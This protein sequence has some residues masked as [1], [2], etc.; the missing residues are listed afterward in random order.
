MIVLSVPLKRV[1]PEIKKDKNINLENFKSNKSKVNS[2]PRW[3][4]L[5]KLL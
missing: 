4:E 3:N 1:N 5:K 2:D